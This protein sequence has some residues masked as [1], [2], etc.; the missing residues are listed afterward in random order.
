[1]PLVDT[2]RIRLEY[3][4]H[5]AADRPALLLLHAL[6]SSLAMW[7]AQLPRLAPHFRVLRCSLRGH[8]GSR[9]R[10]ATVNTGASDGIATFA[11]DACALL[12]ALGVARAHWCGLSLGGMVAMWA[13]AQ[14]PDRVTRLILSN[15]APW[16]GPAAAWTQRIEVV[17]AQ[18]LAPLADATMERWFTAAFREREAAEVARIRGIFLATDPSAYVTACEAIR[19]MDQRAQLG[20]IRAPTLV[21]QGTKDAGTTPETAAALRASIAGARLVTVDAAHLS[22]IEAAEP[23]A[24]ATLAHLGM[25]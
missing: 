11:D 8:G 3:D 23:W 12:D 20:A 9:S 4:Q 22:C 21:I 10:D 13:A 7:D 19:A 24:A 17:R 6:G 25:D 1:M 2:G 5:G 18:G 16:M 14:R 15:T